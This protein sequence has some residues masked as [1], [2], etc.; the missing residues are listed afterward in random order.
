M[1]HLRWIV[2]ALVVLA[3]VVPEAPMAAADDGYC[4]VVNEGEV[5]PVTVDPSE[6]DIPPGGGGP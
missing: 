5:P 6:C 4:V 3:I 1:R 2:P